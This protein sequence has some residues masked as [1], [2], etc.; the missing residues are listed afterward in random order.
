[1]HFKRTSRRWLTAWLTTAL[2]FMQYAV[3]AYACPVSNAALHGSAQ[4]V[5]AMANMAGCAG[6][7]GHELDPAQP[8]L[9]KAH[10]DQGSSSFNTGGAAA[11]PDLPA[12]LLVGLIDWHTPA[13]VQVC[14][15][16]RPAAGQPRTAGPP[17]GWPPLYLSFLVLRN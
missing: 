12:P 7:T 2:L 10:C 15:S 14:S 1:M 13:A 8:Q 6:M 9:C 17:L 4:Q 5:V 3:A 11:S 16:M